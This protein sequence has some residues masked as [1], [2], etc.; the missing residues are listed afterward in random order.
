MSFVATVFSYL[1]I[2]FLIKLDTG[3]KKKFYSL[4]RG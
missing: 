3:L 2:C 1:L 4:D